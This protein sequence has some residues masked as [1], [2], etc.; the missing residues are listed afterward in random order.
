MKLNKNQQNDNKQTLKYDDSTKAFSTHHHSVKKTKLR[1]ACASVHMPGKIKTETEFCSYGMQHEY[2]RN[3]IQIKLDCDKMP[4]H[5]T[6]L[7][8]IS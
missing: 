8:P 4:I 3:Y 6:I 7:S 5:P 2:I 1:H